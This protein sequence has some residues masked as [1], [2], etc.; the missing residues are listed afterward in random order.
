MGSATA[1]EKALAAEEEKDG[2]VGERAA[3]AREEEAAP[4]EAGTQAEARAARTAGWEVE[5]DQ[6]EG[7]RVLAEREAKGCREE[8]AA[9]EKGAATA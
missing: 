2:V 1:G 4:E 7:G 8:T 5:G 3:G 9:G 6:A